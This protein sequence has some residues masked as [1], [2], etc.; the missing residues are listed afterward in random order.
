NGRADILGQ[1]IQMRGIELT[2]TGV[3]PQGF[4]GETIGQQPEAWIPVT[5]QPKVIM[6][7]DRLHDSPPAKSMWLHA[8]GRLKQGAT[9]E[10]ASAQ[11]NAIFKTG[12]ES[13]YA[14]ES[15]DRRSKDID[16]SLHLLPVL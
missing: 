6:G 12:I 11:S 10:Q 14:S 15:A 1:Q 9:I 4:I 3:T 8:F 16:Q 13:Y 5:M 7:E 2:I